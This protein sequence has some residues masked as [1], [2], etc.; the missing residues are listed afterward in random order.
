MIPTVSE[1]DLGVI[2]QGAVRELSLDDEA[3]DPEIRDAF[4]E[5][6]GCNDLA[7]VTPR[8][9]RS[10]RM[11]G[12][13]P[14]SI[15][16]RCILEPFADDL[17]KETREAVE[18]FCRVFFKL[19]PDE[20]KRQWLTFS[21]TLRVSSPYY[22]RIRQLAPGLA[23]DL[24]TLANASFEARKLAER[25][26]AIF[27][28]PVYERS[29]YRTRVIEDHAVVIDLLRKGAEELRVRYPDL[30]ALDV[31]FA[32]LLGMSEVTL[33]DLKNR[34][35]VNVRQNRL[36]HTS[37][38]PVSEQPASEQIP[39]Q[40]RRSIITPLIF[41]AIVFAGLIPAI[42]NWNARRII[43]NGMSQPVFRSGG[44]SGGG[45]QAG[46]PLAY[47]PQL[48]QGTTPQSST[49]QE[50]LQ[51]LSGLIHNSSRPN[52]G[53]RMPNQHPAIPSI[54]NPRFQQPGFNAPRSPGFSP[55]SVPSPGGPSP[56]G[57]F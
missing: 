33:T 56:R 46:L 40:G 39:T 1:R 18:E 10:M 51:R 6:L 25:I 29:E 19:A 20:R 57:N 44:Y 31:R 48:P 47:P 14:Q 13:T 53:T 3:C 2:R 32:E 26:L 16:C 55:P 35:Q 43:Q 21:Q 12:R 45:G 42:S 8:L 23:I 28:R 17:H 11:L 4:L 24:R 49:V 54:P 37:G 50:E 9:Y 34:S 41:A 15:P 30:L 22:L 52:P 7:S 38:Q 5:S 27:C 36:P